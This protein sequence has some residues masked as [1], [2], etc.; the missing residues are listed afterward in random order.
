MS[1][2]QLSCAVSI[3]VVGMLC[4]AGAF[5]ETTLTAQAQSDDGLFLAS[6]PAPAQRAGLCI[7]DTGVNANSD[8]EG[9]VVERTAVDGGTGEDVSP[10]LHGT[11]LAMIA[12]AAANGWGMVGTAPTAIQIVSVRILEPGQT[13][14]PFTAYTTGIDACLRVR[15]RYDVRVINLSLGTSEQPTAEVG[16]LA[17]NAIERASD[18]GVAVVA[19]AGNDNGGGIEY[20]AAYPGVLSVGAI[21]TQAGGFCSFS[22]RGEGLRLTAP[23]CHLDAADPATGAPSYNYWQGTSEAS[24]IA[25]SALTALDAYDPTLSPTAA[26]TALT[27]AHQGALD[28]A[29][30]FRACGLADIVAVGEAAN[31]AGQIDGGSPS[32]KA[33]VAPSTTSTDAR[34][35]RPNARLRRDGKRLVLS[36]TGRP[37]QSETEVRYFGRRK[38]SQGLVVT[39][40]TRGHFTKLLVPGIGVA[41]VAVRYVD[42]YD[43]KRDGPWA[44]LRVPRNATSTAKGK[45]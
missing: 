42:P 4:P 17:E 6:A 16:E 1:R 11:L 32:V 19:A 38:R 34:L 28:I 26:E 31:P 40:T 23:G 22:N 15:S 33:N 21:D 14:F 5:A 24:V 20:P 44:T 9:V 36:T 29:Q 8:T 43:L 13:T 2:K 37:R 12:G 35:P 30:A 45:T 7:V 18:Y 41:Q 27:E 25:A 3:V 39:R 10:T